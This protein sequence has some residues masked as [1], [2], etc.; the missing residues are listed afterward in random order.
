MKKG[1]EFAGSTIARQL[2]TAFAA[3]GEETTRMRPA[4]AKHGTVVL[5]AAGMRSHGR[6]AAGE[7]G[8][9]M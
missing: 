9:W 3:T 7:K 4:R 2:I 5:C 1:N 8:G 6:D